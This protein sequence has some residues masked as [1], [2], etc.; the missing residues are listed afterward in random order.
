MNAMEFF[1]LS[2]GKWR[3]NRITH[4][5]AFRR[6][7]TGDLEVEVSTLPADDPDVLE[8]CQLHQFDP[9]T[10]LG[11]CRVCWG[12]KMAWDKEGAEDHQGSTVMVLVAE[13]ETGRKGRLLREQ[14]YAEKM[15]VAGHFQMDDEDGL[16]LTTEYETMSAVERFSFAS[17][18]LR[19]RTSTV[20]RYGGF[21]TA[22]LCVETRIVEE[23]RQSLG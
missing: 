23:A 9:D 3:S 7:E 22:S 18:D 13:D 14:G 5:L 21:S 17:D 16:V 19:L 1:Q 11:G 12:G 8:L 10:A 2:A 4:H 6:A 15:P 20:K